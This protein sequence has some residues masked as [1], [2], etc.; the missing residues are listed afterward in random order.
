MNQ[1]YIDYWKEHE[2]SPVGLSYVNRRWY[3]LYC[4]GTSKKVSVLWNIVPERI[5]SHHLYWKKR[6]HYKSGDFSELERR[7]KKRDEP[8]R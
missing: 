7:R 2:P 5:R 1:S 8:I 4:D 3:I 6:V